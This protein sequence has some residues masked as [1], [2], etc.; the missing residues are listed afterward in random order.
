MTVKSPVKMGDDQASG[1][2]IFAFLVDAGTE[3][4]TLEMYQMHYMGRC[5]GVSASPTVSRAFQAQ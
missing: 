1:W 5:R 3:I 4:E 2:F